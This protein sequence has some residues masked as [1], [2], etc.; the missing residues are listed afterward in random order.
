MCCLQS[1]AVK[2]KHMTKK[3]NYIQECLN[4]NMSSG[5]EKRGF[6]PC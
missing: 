3:V 5:V 4:Q 2:T 6:I 1:N